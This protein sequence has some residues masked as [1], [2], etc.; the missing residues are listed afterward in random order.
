MFYNQLKFKRLTDET[1]NNRHWGN[2]DDVQGKYFVLV[3]Y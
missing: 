1:F 3:R 2:D